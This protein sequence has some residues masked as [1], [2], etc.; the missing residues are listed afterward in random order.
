MAHCC[1]CSFQNYYYY[2]FYFFK[3][4]LCIIMLYDRVRLTGW[5]SAKHLCLS[6]H[7]SRRQPKT[8]LSAGA[9]K[10]VMASK[11]FS[12]GSYEGMRWRQRVVYVKKTKAHLKTFITQNSYT[13]YNS[14]MKAWPMVSCKKAQSL[15]F[16]VVP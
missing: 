7:N 14:L 5:L 9:C 16:L 4:S 11:S 10:L 3:I 6:I 2:Y 1:F 15:K 12:E 13:P 8:Q